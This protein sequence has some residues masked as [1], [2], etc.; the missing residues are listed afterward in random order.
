MA[1]G[2]LVKATRTVDPAMV[3]EG[4]PLRLTLSKASL[5]RAL[6]I[7]ESTVDELVRRGVLPRPMR[8]SGGCVRWRL[9][10]VERALA[11]IEGSGEHA[12]EHDA[13]TGVQR[14]I[15]AAQDS[16]RGRAA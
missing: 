5:A 9:A 1:G 2:L 11:S 14:A 3:G 12:S 7:S 4:T 16:R 6:D 8:F 10:S 13:L 15:Q